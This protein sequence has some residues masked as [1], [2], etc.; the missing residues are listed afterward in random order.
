MNFGSMTPGA[1][2]KQM[3][4]NVA[5]QVIHGEAGDMIFGLIA[6]K[7]IE[8]LEAVVELH[9]EIGLE[10]I[11][12]VP[13][14]DDRKAQLQRLVEAV[15]ANEI[16]EFWFNEIGERVLE[17]PEDARTYL[18]AGEEWSEQVDKIVRSYRNQGDKR[19]RSEIVADYVNR[20]FGV[21][22]GFFVAHVVV[23]TDDQRQN[24]LRRMMTGN[25]DGVEQAIK[26]ARKEI[27]ESE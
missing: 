27:E 7:E 19:P 16:P 15:M 13:D 18:D 14:A 20:K 10:E 11:E 22:V 24:V 3:M 2:K 8:L 23:W 1:M 9:E 17:N 25:L 26:T 21:E 4:S 6:W 12:Q 5:D